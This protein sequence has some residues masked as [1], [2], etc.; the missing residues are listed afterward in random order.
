VDV[1][2]KVAVCIH[3]EILSEDL[4][5]QPS[6]GVSSAHARS[7]RRQVDAGHFVFEF[8]E[9]RRPFGSGTPRGGPALMSRHKTTGRRRS[10]AEEH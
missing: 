4:E 1:G 8:A 10:K 7:H 9:M 2:K 6:F 3:A 5:S